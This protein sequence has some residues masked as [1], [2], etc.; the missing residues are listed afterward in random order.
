VAVEKGQE[1]GTFLLG[2]SVLL[3][4]AGQMKF[5]AREKGLAIRLGQSLG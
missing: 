3:F 4:F 5:V 2:S 1:L